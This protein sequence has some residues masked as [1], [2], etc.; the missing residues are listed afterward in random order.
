MRFLAVGSLILSAGV[1]GC[2]SSQ[3]Y[4]GEESTPPS[5][6]EQTAV[7][8][9]AR[10]GM[11]PLDF[12]IPSLTDDDRARAAQ[13]LRDDPFLG[14]V[15][16]EHPNA[17][18][19]AFGVWHSGPVKLGAGSD[20]HFDPPITLEHAWPR[21]AA[22]DDAVLTAEEEGALQAGDYPIETTSSRVVDVTDVAI[23]I[24]LRRS[25]VVSI[26]PYK[27]GSVEPAD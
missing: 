4:A 3:Y 24:D 9:T 1:L 5:S 20:L 16:E 7:V 18:P 10:A 2:G 27:Y 14:P 22:N 13:I 12:E 23:L 26:S 21:L 8:A 17:F 15:L 25:D 11:T 19:S 6:S